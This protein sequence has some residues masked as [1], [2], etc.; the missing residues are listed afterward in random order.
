MSLFPLIYLNN[1]RPKTNPSQWKQKKPIPALACLAN[2]YL[3]FDNMLYSSRILNRGCACA[4]T[5]FFLFWGRAGP[6]VFPCRI[7]FG[8]LCYESSR[9]PGAKLLLKLLLYFQ[10]LP[11]RHITTP[12]HSQ[13]RMRRRTKAPR[14]KSNRVVVGYVVVVHVLHAAPTLIYYCAGDTT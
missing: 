13:R 9:S 8:Q 6:S 1:F 12:L 14:S 7:I 2:N 11:D 4:R 3:F 5:L 10:S